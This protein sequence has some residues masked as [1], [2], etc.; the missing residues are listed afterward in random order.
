MTMHLETISTRTLPV[1]PVCSDERVDFN[2]VDDGV[3]FICHKCKHTEEI[4]EE[5][6]GNN[7]YE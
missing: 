4:V 1:C 2:V 5:S 7:I 6:K 3:M